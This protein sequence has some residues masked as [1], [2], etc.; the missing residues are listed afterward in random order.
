M[1][2]VSLLPNAGFQPHSHREHALHFT[3]GCWGQNVDVS[4]IFCMLAPDAYVKSYWILV[5]KM[6]QN[7]HQ[8]LKVPPTHSISDFDV[9]N[10]TTAHWHH[11]KG[12]CVEKYNWSAIDLICSNSEFGKR[13]RRSE[14]STEKEKSKIIKIDRIQSRN[15]NIQF[16]NDKTNAT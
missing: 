13:F 15:G 3:T 4:D 6:A 1:V 12:A 14:I 9:T 7:R 2:A 10:L 11:E 8:H 16:E 5:I